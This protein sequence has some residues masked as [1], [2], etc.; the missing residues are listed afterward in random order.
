MIRKYQKQN[1][2]VLIKLLRQNTPQYF[3]PEEEADFLRYLHTHVQQ[4]LAHHFVYEE[5]GQVLGCAGYSWNREEKSGMVAWFVVDTQQ[6][7]R[8]IGSALLHYCID[9]LKQVKD[10]NKIV[11]RTSQLVYPFFEKAGFVLL[12]TEKDYWAP[13]F[14]LYQMELSLLDSSNSDNYLEKY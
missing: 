12:F 3:A 2:P 1:E 4:G 11:V 10:L 6:Q 8:G 7:G 13:G 5:N 14:D 9:A